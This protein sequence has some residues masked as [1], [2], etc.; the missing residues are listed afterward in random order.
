MYSGLISI[1][2]SRGLPLYRYKLRDVS[3]CLGHENLSHLL[4]QLVCLISSDALIP[5]DRGLLLGPPDLSGSH[6][7]QITMGIPRSFGVA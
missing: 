3:L 6:R 4:T 1:V 5:S 2:D 7:I